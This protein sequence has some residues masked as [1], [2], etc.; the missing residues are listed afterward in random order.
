LSF[1]FVEGFSV[2]SFCSAPS[3]FELGIVGCAVE[4]FFFS[5]SVP[6]LLVLLVQY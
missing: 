4:S 5:F 2:G 1:V 3:P 6:R